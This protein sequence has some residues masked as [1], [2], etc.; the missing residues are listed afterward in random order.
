M[1]KLALGNEFGKTRRIVADVDLG[2][3][4]LGMSICAAWYQGFVVVVM[5]PAA[6]QARPRNGFGGKPKPSAQ[7]TRCAGGCELP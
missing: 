5:C 2:L 4:L 1:S 7:A 3:I 6:R